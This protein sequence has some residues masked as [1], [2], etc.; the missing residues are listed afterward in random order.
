MR[1]AVTVASA[2]GLTCV[3]SLTARL[4]PPER[5]RSATDPI[6]PPLVST[7]PGQLQLQHLAQAAGKL[8]L[9]L[10]AEDL[11][12]PIQQ[13]GWKPGPIASYTT[14]A[15][16][17]LAQARAVLAAAATADRAAGA[18]WDEIAAVLDVSPDT[19]ARRYR[20]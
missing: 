5:D 13:T 1:T 20:T 18:T 11:A 19:A 10:H 3:R 9:D 12:P 4:P 7:N 17:L 14:A 16:P 15:L 2:Q 8:A 6:E